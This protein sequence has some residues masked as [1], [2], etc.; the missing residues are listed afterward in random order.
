M[1]RTKRWGRWRT[2][3]R[4]RAFVRNACRVR[5][6]SNRSHHPVTSSPSANGIDPSSK[7]LWD[8]QPNNL[9]TDSTGKTRTELNMPFYRMMCIA[10]HYPEYVCLPQGS[11]PKQK[12]AVTDN[13]TGEQKHIKDLVTRSAMHVLD[14]GGT[15]RG[16][17]YWGT[18]TLPQRMRRQKQYFNY[19]E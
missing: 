15:V 1:E 5:R 13:L 6:A 19:G 9:H 11:F 8:A 4:L 18:R 14:N 2:R 7:H 12:V 16:F 3:S 17:R 10:A